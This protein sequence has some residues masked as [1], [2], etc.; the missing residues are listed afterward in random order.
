MPR[1]TRHHFSRERENFFEASS[2]AAGDGCFSPGTASRGRHACGS[3]ET[4]SQIC[5]G[6]LLPHSQLS[7][8]VPALRCYLVQDGVRMLKI[9]GN[10]GFQAG[11]TRRSR[12]ALCDT[13]SWVTP[14]VVIVNAACAGWSENG[15]VPPARG[16]ALAG[17]AVVRSTA[18]SA[19]VISCC[20][21]RRSEGRVTSLGVVH[22]G[23]RDRGVARSLLSSLQRR[24]GC[25]SSVSG[26]GPVPSVLR[27]KRKTKKKK[28]RAMTKLA[29]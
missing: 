10:R 1:K 13:P 25:N 24:K 27:I 8:A 16:R 21:L 19:P 20:E 7:S 12:W 18:P 28:K 2:C 14:L 6:K 22:K 23:A 26:D 3:S 4:L 9:P 15:R 29:S 5:F 17:R 11:D